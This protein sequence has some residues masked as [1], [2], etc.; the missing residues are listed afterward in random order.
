MLLT[1]T[2]ELPR[3]TVNTTC[4]S[5]KKVQGISVLSLSPGGRAAQS[6]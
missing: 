5:L 2:I 3:V 4:F 6:H 1:F